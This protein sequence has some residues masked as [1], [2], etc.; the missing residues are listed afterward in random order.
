MILYALYASLL[1]D[2]YD[3]YNAIDK[4]LFVNINNIYLI[5]FFII[6]YLHALSL[7][8]IVLYRYYKMLIT[9]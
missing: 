8:F 1:F 9:N 2:T 6:K 3:A 7:Q 4:L 5:Y